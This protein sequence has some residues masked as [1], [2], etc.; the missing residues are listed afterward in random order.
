ML[1]LKQHILYT[2]LHLYVAAA[3]NKCNY[4]MQQCMSTV[5]A[6]LRY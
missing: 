1:F 6:D 3:D 4:T 2:C 5:K